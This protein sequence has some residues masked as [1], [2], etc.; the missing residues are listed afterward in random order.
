MRE[1]SWMPKRNL[2]VNMSADKRY[3][4]L[5]LTTVE[6]VIVTHVMVSE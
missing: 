2:Q 5:K 4:R 6:Q 3:L 1:A